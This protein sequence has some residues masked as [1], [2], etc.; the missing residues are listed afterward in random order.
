[1]PWL[2]LVLF[3]FTLVTAWDFSDRIRFFPLSAGF[4]GLGLAV[5]ELLTPHVPFLRR[6]FLPERVMDLAFE[7]DMLETVAGQRAT[8]AL[9][10]VLA[11]LVG[12]YLLG[13]H[14]ALMAFM[15]VYLRR[16]AA[17][18]WTTALLTAAGTGLLIFGVLDRLLHVPWP[19][20]VIW[21]WYERLTH[22]A[23]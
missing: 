3:A 18:A 2:M 6:R 7:S 21:Q 11:L 13:F 8:H 14:V 5:V 10:W 1:M 23:Q 12:I 4:L 16:M 19:D 9:G 22:L 15:V 17:A 20:P